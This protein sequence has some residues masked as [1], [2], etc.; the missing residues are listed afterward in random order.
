MSV[1]MI[2]VTD[3]PYPDGRFNLSNP[4]FFDLLVEAIEKYIET[5]NHPPGKK[6]MLKP[7]VLTRYVAYGTLNSFY[8]CY[9]NSEFSK[10]HRR[11][12]RVI[13]SIA[14]LKH[15]RYFVLPHNAIEKI[16]K[17]QEEE[18]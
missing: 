13:R 4:K 11:V 1:I 8:G 7:L 16:R 14:L 5:S 2:K 9:T 10:L 15:G 18:K 17:M 3:V 6:L 12:L